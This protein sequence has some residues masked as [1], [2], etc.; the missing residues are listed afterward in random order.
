MRAIVFLF[1]ALIAVAV[2]AAELSQESL[3]GTWTI[4]EFMGEPDEE[5]DQWKFDGNRFYQV[6]G[7]RPIPPDVFT[8]NGMIIDLDYAKITVKSFDG[9]TMEAEM[10]GFPYK[11]VKD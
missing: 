11:L 8:V 9:N 10:A 4:V 5:G 1:V 3:Q 2:A 6:F 7:G